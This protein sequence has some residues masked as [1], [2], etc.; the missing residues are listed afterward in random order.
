MTYSMGIDIGGT[1]TD[2][3]VVESGRDPCILKCPSTPGEFERGFMNVLGIAAEHYGKD[4]P[5]FLREVDSIVHGTTVSTNALV[6]RN[7]APVGLIATEGHPDVLTL[8]EAPRKRPWNWKL[9][10]PDPYVPRNRTIGVGGRIDALGAEVSPLV[11]NDVRNAVAYFRRAGVEAIAVSL[12]WSIANP[13]HE[14]RVLE[15][16]RE[17]WPEVPVSLSHEVNPI[18]R[19]YRRTISTV[20]DAS[21]RPVVGAY[22][23]GLETALRAAGYRN[24]LL[25]ANCVGGMMPPE[26]IVEKPIYSVMSGPTLAPVAARH[27]T[28]EADVIVVDMGGTTFDVS[29]IRAGQ[30]VVTPEAMIYPHDMLGL[31]KVDVRSVGAGGGSIAWV[32]LGGL[33]RVGP[34]SAGAKPGPA[35][36]G[37]GGT[38]ATVTDA[39]VVLGIIDPD[40]F[41]GG[42]IKLHR[43]LA[44]Q[45]VGK[46]A[47]QLSIG[48]VEAAYAIYTTCNHNMIAAIEDI[49]VN[50]G[51]NP[52]D[53]YLVSGGGATA[54]HIAEMA[55]VL[56]LKRF[57]IPKLSAGLSAFGG[58]VSDIRW[59][60][61][62]SLHTDSRA[63]GLDDVNRLLGELRGRCDA[64]LD[65]A[66]VPPEQRSFEYAFM[67]R[68]EYQSWEIEVPFDPAAGR[69]K[70]GNL[71][72]LVAAFNRMHERIYSIKDETNIV[73]FVTW[74]VTAVGE[75][76]R[77]AG[78]PGNG[79]RAAAATLAPKAHRPVYIH[80]QGGM[81][82]VPVFDGT[83]CVAG[84]KI[85][86]PAVIEESTTTILLLPGMVATTDD[87]G[88]YRIAI[89]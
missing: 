1:F 49:T 53:S 69:L 32:D 83:A 73:E 37:A 26:E 14:L 51:I 46:I 12:L 56:G 33:L 76:R 35:C 8:R 19:E 78:D 70:A 31:P 71:E 65:R 64:F 6:V 57:M 28:T 61:V 10:F 9:D 48:L 18:P 4:L 60:A 81:K 42:R 63:F 59:E 58:L 66:Q 44:E 25:I 39:N 89:E 17:L 87:A 82:P 16:I 22:I 23:G 21:L 45:A 27:L 84:G 7:T 38:E 79:A 13:H 20:I 52:R 54:C 36:Y 15:I 3:V 47:S 80:R 40:F 29:A 86:G 62:G 2:C 55:D 77:I 30:I 50:E 85:V 68:Y 75:G 88:N 41:L 74:K 67:G 5:G 43:N 11:E 72:A 24:R 34:R